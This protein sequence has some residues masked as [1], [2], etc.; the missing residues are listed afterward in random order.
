[1]NG[2]LIR[3]TNHINYFGLK[4]RQTKQMLMITEIPGKMGVR[5]E[6]PSVPQTE[7]WSKI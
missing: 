5:I 4:L 2:F 1:M 6:N 7:H 3:I